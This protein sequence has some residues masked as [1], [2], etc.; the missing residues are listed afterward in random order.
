MTHTTLQAGRS[1]PMGALVRDGG[2]NFCV[3]SANAKCVE[4]CVFDADGRHEVA[5]HTL[6]GPH[7]QVFHG[8]LPGAGPGLIYGL[9]AQ[10]PDV[11]ALGN[12]F[13]PHKLLLDPCAQ[14]I[15]GEFKWLDMHHGHTVGADGA[16]TENTQ[17]N[18]SH[19]LKARVP[20]PPRGP[21]PRANAPRHATSDLVLYE[22]HVKGFS[23]LRQDLP[24]NLRGTYAGLA[25]PSAIAHFKA[26]GLTTLSL[27]PVHY[28][29]DEAGLAARGAVN[30]WGYNTLGFFAPNPRYA[31]NP[32][33]PAAVVEEFRAMVHALHQHGLEVVID[34]VYNHT[35]EGDERG[36]T[37]SFR[38]L[39]H[40]SW[41]RLNP[42]QA[43][44]CENL[45]GCGNTLNAA[46]PR[47]TQFVLDS[48][49]YWVEVMGV[50]GFRF[51][52][53][54]ILGRT[55]DGFD[56]G[57]P[58]FNAIRQDPVLAQVHLIAEPWDAAAGGYQVGRFP[59][60]F[61]DWNDQFRD[62]VRGFWLGREVT[63]GDLARRFTASND[64]FH[65][66]QRRPS[67]SVNFI[68]VHD[69][70]T[71]HDTVSYNHKHN[72][73]NGEDN[74]D[75][76]D[77]ELSFNHG[78]E[79]PTQDVAIQ[80]QRRCVQRSMLA[81]LLLAQGTPMLG[82]GDELGRTQQGNNNAY[83]QDNAINW[84]DW[85][86]ADTDLMAFVG[87]VVA[88]RRAEP[89]LRHDAWFVEQPATADSPRI[90]W[91][92]PHGGSMQP[93]DWNDKQAKGFACMLSAHASAEPL[94]VVFNGHP[95]GLPFSLPH[96]GATGHW[97]V[98]VDASGTLAPAALMRDTINAPSQSLV[99]LR[100][101]AEPLA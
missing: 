71:L 25:H 93:H 74:R 45:S 39:D 53:A 6:H 44:Q 64:L 61:L 80:H 47:V 21:S 42:S 27:L 43:M 101:T 9:R 99:V 23:Q 46:H 58:F 19:A 16:R 60:A 41:Y 7:D 49:R 24:D 86:Q 57:A 72:H 67:A 76:R 97:Q 54:S 63:R 70:F 37:L 96:L 1:A 91:L 30:Y 35:A 98:L 83:C 12:S 31:C 62:A 3:F 94:L 17:D 34:V 14:E 22:M 36:P 88:L 89:V 13:N 68:A 2:V 29:V 79:G 75:G 48:L 85:L 66:S 78:A 4:L 90:Q 10:G 55:R 56:V 65:H 77:H 38:G 51:D 28:P 33:D 73:A 18:A 84:V 59:G 8:F 26:L 100:H 95:H 52:L 32:T 69:G 11:P 50:D 5:R 92:T 87:R 15:V 82:M 81:T 40:A 20:T